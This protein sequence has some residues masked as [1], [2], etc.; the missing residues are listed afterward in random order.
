MGIYQLNTLF[1]FMIL[2]VVFVKFKF[3]FPQPLMVIL[4]LILKLIFH[5][6]L[7]LV[8]TKI[9][10]VQFNS[11]FHLVMLLMLLLDVFPFLVL[12]HLNLT[13]QLAPLLQPQQELLLLPVLVFLF[14]NAQVSLANLFI[15]T[16]IISHLILLATLFTM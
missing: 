8:V 12:L 15:L 7:S 3:Q 9:L 6:H 11:F 16:I 4:M 5:F 13:P 1:N 14:A 10:L 2:L